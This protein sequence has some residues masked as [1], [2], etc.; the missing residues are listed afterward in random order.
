MVIKTASPGVFIQE[1]DLTRGTSDAITTNVGFVA[2]PFVKGPIDTP[3]LVSSEVD[4]RQTFGPVTDDNYE[5]WWSVN[6]FLEYSGTCYVV[7]PSPETGNVVVDGSLQEYKQQS[8]RAAGYTSS[9]STEMLVGKPPMLRN[10]IDTNPLVDYDGVTELDETSKV[11]EVFVKNDN[12]FFE[13]Y[14]QNLMDLDN[15]GVDSK[16]IFIGRESGAWT[17]GLG[18][19]VIDKGADY[20]LTI[21]GSR[22][23]LSTDNMTVIDGGDSDTAGGDEP[24]YGGPIDGGIEA[25]VASVFNSEGILER[26]ERLTRYASI[27]LE[28]CKILTTD[29]RGIGFDS[30]ED[31]GKNF[32]PDVNETD[33]KLGVKGFPVGDSLGTE[34]V[35]DLIVTSADNFVQGVPMGSIVSATLSSIAGATGALGYKVGDRIMIPNP[36]TE[37]LDDAAYATVTEVFGPK[38]QVVKIGTSTGAIVDVKYPGEGVPGGTYDAYGYDTQVLPSE[39]SCSTD[40]DGSI[41]ETIVTIAFAQVDDEAGMGFG[42]AFAEAFSTAQPAA[43]LPVVDISNGG[44]PM[45]VVKE[46]YELGDYIYYGDSGLGNT[47]VDNK[48]LDVVFVPKTYTRNNG[49]EYLWPSQPFGGEK[50]FNYPYKKGATDTYG[51][52]RYDENGMEIPVSG[53]AKVFSAT[54]VHCYWDEF[55]DLW[56][57]RFL[58]QRGYYIFDRENGTSSSVGL[59]PYEVINVADWYSQQ[60]AFQGIPWRA[61]APRP[62]TSRSALEAGA[63]DDE[64]H[65]IVYNI[66]NNYEREGR[67]A[68]IEQYISVSKLRGATTEEGSNNYYADLINR[69]SS[70]IYSNKPLQII[71]GDRAT[72]N[73]DRDRPG[74]LIGMGVKAAYI[75]PRYGTFDTKNEIQEA[76]SRRMVGVE[77]NLI[78]YASYVLA[79]GVDEDYTTD[80]ATISITDAG[81]IQ[82]AYSK[83][84]DDNLDDVD[85][86]IQGPAFDYQTRDNLTGLPVSDPN[87][88]TTYAISKANYLLS[89]G[90]QVKHAMVLLSPPRHLAINP[91]AYRR[92]VNVTSLVN[93][94]ITR[95]LIEYTEQLRSSSYGVMDSGYKYQFDRFREKYMFV[96]MNADVAG[97]MARTSLFSE[98]FFSPAGISRGQINNVTRLAYDPAK[99]KRDLLFPARINPIC[100]FPGQGTVLYGD[101][102][103]LGYRS[104]F[105]RINVRKLFL[106]VEREIGKIARNVLFEFNDVV[107]RTNFKNNTIPFLRD[108]QSKR[109]IID[110]LVV[111]DDS[112]NTPEVI[113]RNEFVADFYI[114]P[115]RSINFVK[116]NFVAT[117][118]GTS[119]AEAVGLFRRIEGLQ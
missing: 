28:D 92:N 53:P 66:A 46:L 72:L 60:I 45:G 102:T 19:A 41:M 81:D 85:Y 103:M 15:L 12:E 106:Y 118:T 57:T 39:F 58:P 111:C 98:P 43:G 37:N 79:G 110:F 10:S 88:K 100:S 27:L 18:I 64:C 47:N 113:D 91:N 78:R 86:I 59:I 21:S 1:V 114:K 94:E 99:D 101:K 119:F 93:S 26:G 74:T 30:L 70:V 17:N 90:E 6:N 11:S 40:S 22:P 54:G 65:I 55:L 5:Y 112:N 31:R 67:G 56:V 95:A 25:K 32:F 50:V 89:L 104:A 82:R 48:L 116:L 33:A 115:N 8:G 69:D 29:I 23:A 38:G 87:V 35:L 77:D 24:E 34:V 105:D 9:D 61:F 71:L 2:G 3:I 51:E 49:I 76:R 97:T 117:K 36:D 68:T 84:K 44:A 80:D 42:T 16:A 63:M 75:Q 108:V 13:I 62:G 96:P 109:G 83:I 7:R 52:K 107:T 14:D 20:Q 73:E 4:F